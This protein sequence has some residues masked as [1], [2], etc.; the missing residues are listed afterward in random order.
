MFVEDERYAAA[1]VDGIFHLVV[2]RQYYSDPLFRS[3]LGGDDYR[4]G[5]QAN[6]EVL[7][8]NLLSESQSAKSAQLR[9][10]KEIGRVLERQSVRLAREFLIIEEKERTVRNIWKKVWKSQRL[11]TGVWRPTTGF[12]MQNDTIIT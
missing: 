5:V 2:E 10:M 3:S 1:Q 4:V 12:N 6:G 9:I 8:S 7:I 11:F